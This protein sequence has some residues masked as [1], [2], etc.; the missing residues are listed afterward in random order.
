[1]EKT[2][3]NEP[4]PCGSGKKYKKCCLEKE[5]A[6]A[7]RKREAANTAPAVL[8]WLAAQLPEQVREAV[9]D[10]FYGGLKKSERALLDS[11]GTKE[12]ELLS[13]NVGEWLLTD[14]VLRIGDGLT[15]VRRLL[16][17]PAGPP[18]APGGRHWLGRLADHALK[19]YEVRRVEKGVGMML[20]DMLDP[21]GNHLWVSERVAS[22]SF[23]RWQVFGARV[24][25]QGDQNVLSGALYPL[26][27]DVAVESVARIRRRTRG[28]DHGSV[29]FREKCASVIITDWLRSLLK[30]SSAP[31][32]QGS[33]SEAADSFE[34]CL[35]AA[36]WIDEPLDALAGK[37]PGEAVKTAAGRRTVVE[38]LKNAE[39]RD[40]ERVR[41]QG[42]ERFPFLTIWQRLGLEPEAC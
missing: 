12:Q 9:E 2:G 35:D 25:V 21:A 3:R 28:E 29:L 24:I 30:D 41:S 18:L 23:L 16:Q 5:Q 20:S 37:S 1:M 15:P 36:A 6:A 10:Q 7:S 17:G 40:Q 33:E 31:A 13:V 27:R 34:H 42:G 26:D 19:L 4:C 8:E 39:L 22:M 14:A 11:L 32:G 38:I